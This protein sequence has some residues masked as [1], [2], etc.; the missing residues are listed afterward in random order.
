MRP[1]YYDESSKGNYGTL[2]QD[3]A[4][5]LGYIEPDSLMPDRI[6]ERASPSDM[7]EQSM[8]D[9][10]A[11][12]P[13]FVSSDV[14]R[15]AHEL[16]TVRD[17][18]LAQ[19]VARR[20]KLGMFATKK[21]RRELDDEID[22]RARLYEAQAGF[23]DKLQ[24]ETWKVHQPGI[25]EEE[26][27]RKLGEHHIE[28]E[29]LHEVH[30]DEAFRQIRRFGALSKWNDQLSEWYIGLSRERRIGVAIGATAI[31]AAVS[32]MA[33]WSADGLGPTAAVVGGGMLAGAKLYKAYNQARLGI[34]EEWSRKEE[35]GKGEEEVTTGKTRRGLGR[36]AL[37][38]AQR[39]GARWGSLTQNLFNRKKDSAVPEPEMEVQSGAVGDQDESREMRQ[40]NDRMH[41]EVMSRME[42]RRRERAERAD[43][44]NKRAR[45]VVIGAGV[46]TAVGIGSRFIDFGKIIDWFSGPPPV[47]LPSPSQSPS[48]S[49]ATPTHS[50]PETPPVGDA[51]GS[52][53]TPPAEQ[54]P[55]PKPPVPTTPEY[56][57]AATTVEDGE[58]WYQTFGEMGIANAT[59]Q[60][61]LLNRVGPDL[62]ANG[63][64]YVMPDGGYGISRPGMLPREALDLI[65]RGR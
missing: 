40:F 46:L 35:D 32:G 56:G 29:R 51:D 1:E 58:G 53:L 34:Y 49:L 41:T 39:S 24:I 9:N 6:D 54:P 28:Q 8:T 63:W 42:K 45:V 38:L 48:P 57:V 14:R 43:K 65:V 62:V 13:Y 61:N 26:L 4:L 50:I 25:E 16:Y 2:G 3:S 30:I 44:V 17:I 10:T 12:G 47:G 23:V 19:V 18:E 52:S 36:A 37:N 22:T 21:T 64:A 5:G 55:Q 15:D 20:I 33:A 11:S 7:T 60:A 31:S 59:D 27:A